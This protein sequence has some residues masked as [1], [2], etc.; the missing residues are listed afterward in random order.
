MDQTLE[1]RK[2]IIS[3][4]ELVEF[5]RV[6]ESHHEQLLTSASLSI[7]SSL[8]VRARQTECQS[9]FDKSAHSDYLDKLIKRLTGKAPLT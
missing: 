6:L 8:C 1:S 7:L 5:T 4:H 2:T 3:V 9:V